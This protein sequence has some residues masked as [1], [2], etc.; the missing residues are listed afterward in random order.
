MNLWGWL[1]DLP[2]IS[3]TRPSCNC[4]D[5]NWTQ[6]QERLLSP[7]RV[8]ASTCRRF[9]TRRTCR[10]GRDP[11][12]GHKISL[13]KLK[14]LQENVFGDGELSLDINIR[15]K[16]NSPC[17]CQS[18]AYTPGCQHQQSL[19]S[20]SILAGE[21]SSG[22]ELFVWQVNFHKS[23]VANKGNLELL[24]ES[25]ILISGKVLRE[26]IDELV[27]IK[28]RWKNSVHNVPWNKRTRN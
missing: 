28:P 13:L 9:R 5:V 16:T 6:A 4:K 25:V 1:Q 2:G 22:E 8:S 10:T 26:K 23:R 21:E 3:Y 7:H 14:E 15:I 27:S 11:P 18:L 24:K 17:T 20:R 19:P 12:P